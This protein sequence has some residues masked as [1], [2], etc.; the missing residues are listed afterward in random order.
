MRTI[1]LACALSGA[2]AWCVVLLNQESAPPAAYNPVALDL[3]DRLASLEGRLAQ[4]LRAV[5]GPAL[6]GAD[7]PDE[8]PAALAR[9]IKALEEE[10]AKVREELKEPE[11]RGPDIPRPQRGTPPTGEDQWEKPRERP[12]VRERIQAARQRAARLDAKARARM[13]DALAAEAGHAGLF[14]LQEELLREIIEV[15]GRDSEAGREALYKVG[16]ARRNS[17]DP[18]AAREA[19][20]AA[21]DQ[22]PRGHFR[23]GYARFYA[24]EMA[25]KAGERDLAER[26]LHD[27]IRDIQAHPKGVDP[28]GT[29]LKR[30]RALLAAGGD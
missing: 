7:R 11:A 30:S 15:A 18:A 26:E 16:W 20:L 23:Q 9:R 3:E 27:L 21:V 29:L 4:V 22:L 6:K 24:A 19:W 13:L 12:S 17:G 14:A 8:T 28:Y 2:M 1:L 5:E 10:L 25:V